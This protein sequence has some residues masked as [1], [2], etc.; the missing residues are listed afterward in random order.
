MSKTKTTAVKQVDFPFYHYLNHF[1]RENR[2]RIRNPFS[3]QGNLAGGL[4]LIRM[5]D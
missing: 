5:P 3:S 1:Y 4:S 2:G